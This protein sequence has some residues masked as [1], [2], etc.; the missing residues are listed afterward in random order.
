MGLLVNIFRL[1]TY[2]ICHLIR[3]TC[4]V[5]SYPYPAQSHIIMSLSWLSCYPFCTHFIWYHESYHLYLFVSVSCE[6]KHQ[7][8]V[9]LTLQFLPSKNFCHFPIHK[10][11]IRLL[12]NFHS[13]NYDFWWL[14]CLQVLHTFNVC[15]LLSYSTIVTKLYHILSYG[16]NI[17]YTYN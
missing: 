10:F 11:C 3:C 8:H 12:Q 4:L 9:Y 7:K 14:R 1:G 5:W 15:S 17:F 13:L 2:H 16:V 6:R